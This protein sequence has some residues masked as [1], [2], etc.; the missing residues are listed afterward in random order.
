MKAN[1]ER[2][3][4]GLFAAALDAPAARRIT[5]DLTALRDARIASGGAG[6]PSAIATDNPALLGIACGRDRAFLNFANRAVALPDG[7]RDR[8]TG[9]QCD[10][11]E[12]WGVVWLEE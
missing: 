1:C 6:A 5:A 8:L 10:H 3:V 12:A 2:K 4:A 7:G 11:V 9:A